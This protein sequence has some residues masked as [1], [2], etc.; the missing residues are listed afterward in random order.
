MK[1]SD[2]DIRD[3]DSNL[4][5]KKVAVFLRSLFEPKINGRKNYEI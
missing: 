1:I 5:K 4:N 3:L 2:D